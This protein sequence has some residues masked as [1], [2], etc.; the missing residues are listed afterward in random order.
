VP[1]ESKTAPRAHQE[2]RD[3]HRLVEEFPEHLSRLS[4]LGVCSCG[5]VLVRVVP[6]S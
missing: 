4:T 6:F 5:A 2:W 1:L 3:G